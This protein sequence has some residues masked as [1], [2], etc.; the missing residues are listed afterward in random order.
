[1]SDHSSY[2]AP[3]CMWCLATGSCCVHVMSDLWV[4]LCACDVW[5]L[6]PTVH[7]MSDHWAPLCAC[8][9]WPLGPTVCMWCLTTG[10]HCVHVMSDHWAPLCMWC[11]LYRLLY[12]QRSRP[13]VAIRK[14]ARRWHLALASLFR[15][16]GR[17][18]IPLNSPWSCT[19][20][21]LILIDVSIWTTE[22]EI[23]DF[24]F[25]PLR[26]LFKELRLMNQ[27]FSH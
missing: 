2:W 18:A 7:V 25:S 6:G 3:L 21:W 23:F 12:N 26:C 17:Y 20:S 22:G 1:M 13:L 9:V 10:S 14:K 11:Y 27:T 5:P 24:S 4:P 15:P 16:V 19:R 8:D